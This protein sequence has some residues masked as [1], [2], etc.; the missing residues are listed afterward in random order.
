MNRKLLEIL[1][2]PKDGN[3][4][5]DLYVFEEDDEIIAGI[6]ICPKCK[7]WYPIQEKLPEMLPDA[8][9]DKMGEI[10]FLSKWKSFAPQEILANGK[11]FN[12][13]VKTQKEI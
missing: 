9:R 1:A 5:L 3:F 10:N 7:R 4:P 2:C 12:L 6:I 11:P 8:L 13:S